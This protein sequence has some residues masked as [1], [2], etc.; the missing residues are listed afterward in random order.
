MKQADAESTMKNAYT[1]D[2]HLRAVQLATWG[3]SVEVIALDVTRHSADSIHLALRS[4][5]GEPGMHSSAL[6]REIAEELDADPLFTGWRDDLKDHN[7]GRR[8]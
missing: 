3:M 1:R 4:I 7:Y 6:E 8:S 2:E 5:G